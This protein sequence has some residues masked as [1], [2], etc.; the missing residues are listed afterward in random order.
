MWRGQEECETF[1]FIREKKIQR[2]TDSNV[3]STGDRQ[4]QQFL[5]TFIT[6]ITQRIHAKQV[7]TSHQ[8]FTIR[9]IFG[10]QTGAG[11]TGKNTNML[12][13]VF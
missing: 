3:A 2:R 9:L 5:P 4:R 13:T 7:L 10:E 11:K 6:E 12:I 1:K 8:V